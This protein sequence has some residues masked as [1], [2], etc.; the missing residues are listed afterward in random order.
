M[1]LKVSVLIA[2]DNREFCDEMSDYIKASTDMCLAGVANDGD[3]AYGMICATRP[4]IVILDII[5]PK[6]DGI[7]LLKKLANTKMTK[8]PT[9]IAH[10]VTGNEK[11]MESC[12]QAGA[13]YFLLKPQTC[14]A[15]AD[16]I[17]TLVPGNTSA[18]VQAPPQT[19]KAEKET[20][21]ETVVTEFMH[22]LG[23][24]AHIKGYQYI[25]TAIM[26]VVNNMDLLNYITKQLYPDIAK[27]Y[28]ST[29]SRVER[30]IR[31]SIEVAWTRGRPETMNN[32]FGY[33]IDTGKGKP[34]NSEFI[35]MVA[36]RIRLQTK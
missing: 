19:A 27:K 12:Y 20:D 29:S 1:N 13:E 21:L 11:V 9:V 7:S 6:R 25:R 18:T 16:T 33:T 34:T 10:S 5:M 30:A 14:E 23:M 32:I 35:A 15:I 22:E 26:M 4:D 17:R 36:D 8:R 28:G 24:P 3:E 31:H 2:D